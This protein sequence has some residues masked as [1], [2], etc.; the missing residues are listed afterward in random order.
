[1]AS[2]ITPLICPQCGATI[3][4]RVDEERARCHYCGTEFL[5]RDREVAP[6]SAPTA[7]PGPATVSGPA[8]EPEPSPAFEPESKPAPKKSLMTMIWYVNGVGA[9]SVAIVLLVFVVRKRTERRKTTGTE[10]R[11]TTDGKL[12]IYGECLE[13]HS[14][15]VHEALVRYLSWVND[16]EKG[17]TCKERCIGY[18]T[19]QIA[20]KDQI[21][22]CSKRIGRARRQKPRM[23]K[24][25]A[26]AAQMVDALKDVS[27]MA[28]QIEDYI[29]LKEYLDDGC[30]KARKLHPKYIAAFQRFA[31]AEEVLREAGR[32]ELPS[33]IKKRLER[34][35]AKHGRDPTY[36]VKNHVLLL[37][38][39][40][41]KV[42]VQYRAAAPDWSWLK[43]AIAGLKADRK[44]VL[45]S[46]DEKSGDDKGAGK[47][48]AQMLVFNMKLWGRSFLKAAD[49]LLYV[50]TG[51]QEKNPNAEDDKMRSKLRSL[52]RS[53][54]N[55][56]K[57]VYGPRDASGRILPFEVKFLL[58]SYNS[59]VKAV[60]PEALLL[61][62]NAS[63]EFPCR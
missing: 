39:F 30:A 34:R 26:A 4:S 16:R 48:G 32:K 51:Q 17:P 53:R 35:L 58:S 57:S 62:E 44:V 40:V 55:Q 19:Y 14:E 42:L 22:D 7:A 5:L 38:E 47:N 2:S 27:V 33:L 37:F 60:L 10:R 9:L 13:M 25:E 50:R 45:S 15:R 8:S 49:D 21:D 54:G 23:P 1:M 24:I 36:L 11:K 29:S 20:S 41:R 31:R 52:L 6:S 56:V 43:D 18:G 12:T 46:V 28:K 59:L 63:A 3:E 61:Q